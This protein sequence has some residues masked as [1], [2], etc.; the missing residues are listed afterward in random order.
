MDATYVCYLLFTCL[1]ARVDIQISG[2][3]GRRQGKTVQ[4]VDLLER[5]YEF[6]VYYCFSLTVLFFLAFLPDTY[7]VVIAYRKLGPNLLHL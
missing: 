2:K 4:N 7:S 1:G 3:D 6:M 5:H